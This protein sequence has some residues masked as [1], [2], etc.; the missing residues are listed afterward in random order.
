MVNHCRE[1]DYSKLDSCAV[2]QSMYRLES[3]G[4]CYSKFKWALYALAALLI[5]LVVFAGWWVAS[6]TMREPV[7]KK[8][9]DK[10]MD[11][12]ELQ[13]L[14]MPKEQGRKIWDIDTNLLTT[15]VAGPG[16]LLHFNFQAL[17]I[18][19]PLWLDWAGLSLLLL[20]I[21]IFSS[22]GPD[23][24]AH[25]E[26][27]ASLLRGVSGHSRDSCGPRFFSWLLCMWHPPFYACGTA[28]VSFVYFKA[29]TS[30]RRQ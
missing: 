17:I 28:S 14:R 27:T 1:Y 6:M 16:M 13:K 30:R 23:H 19:G 7:N 2:C 18:F 25:L 11:A 3:D 10:A 15:Q 22:W 5:F 12:R 20:L 8:T 29:W 24:S 4:Q 21:M 26:T 9:L